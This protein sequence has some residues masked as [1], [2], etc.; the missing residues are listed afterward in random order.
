MKIVKN[1]WVVHIGG[2]EGV[3]GGGQMWGAA[4]KTVLMDISVLSVDNPWTNGTVFRYILLFC[5]L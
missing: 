1:I 2:D 5:K 3:G 4:G